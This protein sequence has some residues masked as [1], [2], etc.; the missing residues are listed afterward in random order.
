V[1]AAAEY[2]KLSRAEQASRLK[3]EA[4]ALEFFLEVAL[5]EP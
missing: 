5:R 3:A 4:A 1:A 2:E